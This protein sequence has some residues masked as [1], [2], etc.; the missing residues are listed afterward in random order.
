M[1]D[2]II[3]YFQGDFVPFYEKYL[4]EIQ[5]AGGHEHKTKCPFHQEQNA[6]FYI[7]GETG[8]YFCQGCGKK[9]DIFHFYAK[10][11]GL[12][13]RRDFGK[14]LKGIS[15]DFGIPWKDRPKAK[16]VKAYDYTDVEGN[17]L[18]QVCRMEPKDFRQRRPN[19]NGKWIWN[20]KGVDRVLYHLPQI[21]R[22]SE[23]IVC[24][25][26]KD[27]D[28]LMNMGF[29]ATTCPMGAKKWRPE[30]NASA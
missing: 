10:V 18:F 4:S 1:K 19:G 7:N 27:A 20:L 22:A 9:G 28:T 16:M 11:S 23:V 3:D 30:Y 25:G 8:Q 6:S 17:L 21:Q 2:S 13:T 15:D 12:D 5:K 14:V 26:E 24:E 29:V